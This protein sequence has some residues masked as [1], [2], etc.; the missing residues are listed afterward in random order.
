MLA[1][2]LTVI[3]QGAAVAYTAVLEGRLRKVAWSK[4]PRSA[5]VP[6]PGSSAWLSAPRRETGPLDPKPLPQVLE[7]A[8][9]PPKPP[10]APP[11]R[12]FR[13]GAPRPLRAAAA[14]APAAQG[15]REAAKQTNG[16]AP[17]TFTSLTTI[18]GGDQSNGVMYGPLIGVKLKPCGY[19]R[20]RVSRV[21]RC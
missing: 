9:S 21:I 13:Q 15:R 1:Y 14:R 3:L 17:A 20:R 8:A 19:F 7:L 11:L 2:S 6:P 12:P 4:C 10:I 16:R 5:F 18:T